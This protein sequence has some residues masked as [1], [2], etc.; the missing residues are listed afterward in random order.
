MAAGLFISLS[1]A[2]HFSER[3]NTIKA[4]SSSLPYPLPFASA[5]GFQQRITP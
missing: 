5:N 1:I 3:I 4:P 2:V